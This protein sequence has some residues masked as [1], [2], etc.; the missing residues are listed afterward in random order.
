LAPSKSEPLSSFVPHRGELHPCLFSL[1]LVVDLSLPSAPT[2]CRTPPPPSRT[3]EEAPPHR[4]RGRRHHLPTLQTVSSDHTQP[5]F[6]LRPPPHH[7]HVPGALGAVAAAEVHQSTATTPDHHRTGPPP[8]RT[9]APLLCHRA[10]SV[11]SYS[12]GIAR[13][14]PASSLVPSVKTEW[15]PDR[16]IASG[17]HATAPPRARAPRGDHARAAP[18]V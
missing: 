13:R 3:V 14:H 6:N 9:E 11:S 8:R 1:R 2:Y 18:L 16:R 5:S 17:K 7:S 12:H 15:L 10:S 4:N